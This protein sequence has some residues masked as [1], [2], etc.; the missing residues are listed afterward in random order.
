MSEFIFKAAV[1]IDRFKYPYKE[2]PLVEL[3]GFSGAD[4]TDY[5]RVLK[6]PED[7]KGLKI[8][9]VGAGASEFTAE[10][11]DRG[12][13]AYAID[14]KYDFPLEQVR[15]GATIYIRIAPYPPEII[16]RREKSVERFL[17]SFEWNR[18]RY[19]AGSAT[20]MPF[21]DSNFDVVCSI[22]TLTTYLDRDYDVFNQAIEEC[23]RVTRVGGSIQLFP[24]KDEEPS[25]TGKV[26]QARLQNQER[27]LNALRK[28]RIVDLTFIRDSHSNMRGIIL[29]KLS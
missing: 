20:S 24:Y 23:L 7:V 6:L 18:T 9:D 22:N 8:L 10:L 25:L 11:L 21:P 28:N 3:S 14:P 29:T 4:W 16:A 1:P 5:L 27:V 15:E 26:N 12:A 2:I 17:R 19:V 13:N